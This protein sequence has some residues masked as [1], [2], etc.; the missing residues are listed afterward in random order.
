LAK[1][2][3][4]FVDLPMVDGLVFVTFGIARSAC[5]GRSHSGLVGQGQNRQHRPDGVQ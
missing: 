2:D 1:F 5:W 3:G 4:D